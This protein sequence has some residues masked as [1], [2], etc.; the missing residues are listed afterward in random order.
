MIPHVSISTTILGVVIAIPVKFGFDYARDFPNMRHAQRRDVI[1]WYKE[2][3]QTLWNINFRC[4]EAIEGIHL[5]EHHQD[6]VSDGVD[7]T[8]ET[9][10]DH[11]DR[12]DEHQLMENRRTE[13]QNIAFWTYELQ[14]KP[15][16]WRDI[17]GTK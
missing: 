17:Y 9:I 3:H 16:R 10:R 8:A 5:V 14:V 15:E 12:A 13:V 4:T 1:E 11:Y 6:K 7:A 2:L